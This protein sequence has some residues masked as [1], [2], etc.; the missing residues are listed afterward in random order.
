MIKIR[1]GEDEYN[2][3]KLKSTKEITVN[4]S[5]NICLIVDPNLSSQENIAYEIS[6]NGQNPVYV[7]KNNTEVPKLSFG[8]TSKIAISVKKGFVFSYQNID[9]DNGN[10]QIEYSLVRD[11]TA[12]KENQFLPEGEE[13]EVRIKNA[14]QYTVVG[15]AIEA[16]ASFGTI[17]IKDSTNIS[18]FAVQYERKE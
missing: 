10:L 7:Y 1:V 11:H 16:G 4:E 13:I 18:D 5:Q 6:I 3:T 8:G 2:Y 17:T 14:D 9:N 15:G 12:L